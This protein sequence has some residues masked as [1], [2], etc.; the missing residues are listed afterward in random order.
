MLLSG[1]GDAPPGVVEGRGLVDVTTALPAG[2]VPG[3]AGE[4][5]AAGVGVRRGWTTPGATTVVG[6]ALLTLLAGD[7]EAPE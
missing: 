7:S 2:G 3:R 5:A 4:G 6:R 1:T